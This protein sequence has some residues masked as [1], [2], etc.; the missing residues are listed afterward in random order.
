MKR[1]CLLPLALFSASVLAN[2]A[3]PAFAG[4]NFSGVYSC[5]G[6]NNKVGDYEVL[7]TL[8]LNR[9]N[10][11]GNFGVYDFSTETENA[12]VYKGQAI[13]NGYKLALTFNLSD[14]R[15]AEY[16]TGITDVKR[17]SSTRWAYTNNYYE[18]DENGGDYGQEYCLMQKPVVVSK[19]AKKKVIRNAGLADISNFS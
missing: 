1:L 10:S 3:L 8:K 11:H 7:A 13:S 9:P 18:P 15:N 17:I 12:L 16:S 5:K 4:P 19:K 6:T 14:T 2:E